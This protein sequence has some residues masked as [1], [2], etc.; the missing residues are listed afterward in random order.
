MISTEKVH[1]ELEKCL[2]TTVWQEQR[3]RI[4]QEESLAAG[5]LNERPIANPNVTLALDDV[6]S[7]ALK[8]NK[9]VIIS[10]NDDEKEVARRLLLKEELLKVTEKYIK[11]NCPACP[12]IREARKPFLIIFHIIYMIQR[13]K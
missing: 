4:Q 3:K 7:T 5:E 9:R 10:E 6:R 13:D 12:F 1:V 11:E 8:N 2:I